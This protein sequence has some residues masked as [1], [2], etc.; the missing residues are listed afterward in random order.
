MKLLLFKS[1]N[2][3][4]MKLTEKLFGRK[5]LIKLLWN[6]FIINYEFVSKVGWNLSH[7]G[8]FMIA[9]GKVNGGC[10]SKRAQEFCGKCQ[11]LRWQNHKNSVTKGWI[12][13]KM[14]TLTRENITKNWRKAF[15][16]KYAKNPQTFQ[17]K[18]R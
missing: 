10:F 16:P 4:P 5:K 2:E 3:T 13:L 6:Y 14:K 12:C 17:N 1:Y 18:S 8:N 7:R 11:V 9:W 15:L